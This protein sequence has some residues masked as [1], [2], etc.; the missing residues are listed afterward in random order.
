MQPLNTTI[1]NH[2]QFIYN[3]FMINENDWEST[4]IEY[5]HLQPFTIHLQLIYKQ[6]QPQPIY[7]HL[8]FTTIKYNHLQQIHNQLQPIYNYLQSTTIKYN[9]S[10]QIYNQL[11]LVY[12]HLQQ[13]Y[14]WFTIHL[15]SMEPIYNHLQPFTIH[16]QSMTTNIQPVTTI[17]NSFT[18]NSQTDI[19]PFTIHSH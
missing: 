3:Q 10:Q 1:Y 12:N 4:T 14:K 19:Q 11:Q 5:N 17:Y 13:I 16:L 8:Q 6:L 2:L 7:N 15:Q 18:T 9:K